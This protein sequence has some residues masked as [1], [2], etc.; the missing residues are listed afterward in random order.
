MPSLRRMLAGAALVVGLST[1]VAFTPTVAGAQARV[2]DEQ[3]ARAVAREFF[4]SIN[5]RQFAKTC[6]LLSG[7]YY[8]ANRIPDSI[9]CAW[10]L[11]LGF[12]WQQSIRFKI[13]A[14]HVR[15]GRAIVAALADGVPGTLLI[16]KEDGA[17]KILALSGS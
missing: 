7:R 5:A 16:A 1:L 4:R 11:T 17:F 14:I 6:D 15:D 9:Q 10:R 12:A 2:L 3:V 13:G 8:E